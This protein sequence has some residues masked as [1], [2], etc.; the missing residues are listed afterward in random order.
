MNLDL[1]AFVEDYTWDFYEWEIQNLCPYILIRLKYM[2]LRDS[3]DIFVQNIIWVIDILLH[4]INSTSLD[5]TMVK[6]VF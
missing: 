6:N 1:F 3:W 2:T 5:Q 4:S